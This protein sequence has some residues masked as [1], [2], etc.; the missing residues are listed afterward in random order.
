MK[1]FSFQWIKPLQKRVEDEVPERGNSFMKAWSIVSPV[2]IYYVTDTF[3]FM[4][5][6]Y[7]IL[8][9]STHNGIWQSLGDWIRIHSTM[10]SAAVNGI[11][12]LIGAAVVYKSF[13]N[14]KI[15]IRLPE[16]HRKDVPLLLIMGGASALGFNILFSL[17]KITENSGTYTEI[18]DRQFSLPLWAGIILYGIISPIAEEI[19][20]RGLVYNRLYRQFGITMAIL[21][22]AI[23]FGVYHGNLVQALYGFILGIIMAILYERYGSFV[24]PVL[25][26][27]AANIC[28]YVMSSDI[29]LQQKFVNG[30]GCIACG[31]L[32]VI[33]FWML[34]L[35]KEKVSFQDT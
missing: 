3:F 12:M 28:V 18:A 5:F 11:A 8:G 20:F 13:Q 32:S 35:R 1:F 15:R 26:H 16:L 25:L 19:V 30:T 34:V 21:G 31:A 14:E 9:I 27:S 10:V 6:T 7:I 17:L 33:L 23:L 22:S 4:L 29:D 24:V 2:L